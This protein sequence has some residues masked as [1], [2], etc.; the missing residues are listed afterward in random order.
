MA[1]QVPLP[2]WKT[3]TAKERITMTKSTARAVDNSDRA[4]TSRKKA[5]SRKR[6]ECP[7]LKM[8]GTI[9]TMTRTVGNGGHFDGG[10]KWRCRTH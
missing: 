3:Q 8:H 7:R 9:P 10:P 4:A 6:Y 1:A 2:S 5:S